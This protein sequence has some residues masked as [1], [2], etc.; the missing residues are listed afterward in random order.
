MFELYSSLVRSDDDRVYTYDLYTA[1]PHEWVNYNGSEKEQRSAVGIVDGLA[2]VDADAEDK[3]LREKFFPMELL[4]EGLDVKCRDGKASMEADRVRILGAIGK[5]AQ[6]LDATIHGRVAAA[7][8]RRALEE[9][10]EQAERFLEAVQKGRLPKFVLDMEG[11]DADNESTMHHMCGA[12]CMDTEGT[13]QTLVSL[14]LTRSEGLTALHEGNKI[15]F[16]LRVAS[17]E[18]FLSLV[19]ILISD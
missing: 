10:S 16:C 15:Y 6:Q 14:T 4:S 12:L 17:V 5:G 7:G 3:G 2:A 19:Q 9:G 13:A 8:L 11:S 1:A 18:P